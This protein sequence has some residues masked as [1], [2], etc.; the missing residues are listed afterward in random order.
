MF[1]FGP[2]ATDL[3]GIMETP[4]REAL[5][6]WEKSPALSDLSFRL[7]NGAQAK[8]WVQTYLFVGCGQ[9]F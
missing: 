8:G 7:L 2:A 9:K 5:A 3:N 6:L 4:L 1:R